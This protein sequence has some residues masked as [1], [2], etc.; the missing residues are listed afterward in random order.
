M[1][2]VLLI[3]LCWIDYA[4]AQMPLFFQNYFIYLFADDDE[5]EDSTKQQLLRS[6]SMFNTFLHDY[7]SNDN[8][9]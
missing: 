6:Q 8:D 4:H 9:L 2:K 3:E 5:A 1:K 7:M